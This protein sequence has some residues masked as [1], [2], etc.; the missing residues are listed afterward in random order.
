M[1]CG[2]Y[3]ITNLITQKSYI[4]Q[5]INI[6]KR[7]TKEKNKAFNPESNE[8]NKTLSKAFRKYGIKN[9]KFEILEECDIKDLDVKEKHFI[10]VYNT[11]FNGYNETTGGNQGNCNNCSKISKEDLIQIYELLLTTN[12]PQNEIAQR[13]NVGQDVISTINQ[14]KSRRLEGYNYPLRNNRKEKKYCCD[15]GKEITYEAIRCMSCEKIRQRKVENRPNRVLLKEMIRIEP[16]T[17][18]AQKYGVSDNA[19][20][21]WCINYNLPSTKKQINSYSDKEWNLI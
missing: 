13:F 8:Y 9:F 21:K 14:G 10:K 6:Q 12:I 11:Y 20:R 18:I 17:K 16:F 2:I 5:S 3:K 7:W 1:A 15:C 19:I 4:G